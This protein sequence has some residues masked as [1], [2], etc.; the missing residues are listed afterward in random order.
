MH[1][2]KGSTQVPQAFAQGQARS[3]GVNTSLGDKLF[4]HNNLIAEWRPDGL[5]ISNGGYTTYSRGGNEITGSRT[6]KEKLNALPGV[7]LRQVNCK[8]ILNGKEWDGSWIRIKGVKVP[9]IDKTKSGNFYI[10]GTQWESTGGYRGYEQPIHACVGVNNT[11]DWS[12]SPCPSHIAEAEINAVRDMLLAHKIK[13]KL[14]TCP[15]SNVFCVHHYLVPQLKNVVV[16]RG[17]VEQYIDTNETRLAYVV[18]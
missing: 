12:D 15:S 2:Y 6:T 1:G 13:T 7:S 9:K 10:L 5:W 18:K 8:W 16:A 14:V 11:G 3:I 17:L 4:Y